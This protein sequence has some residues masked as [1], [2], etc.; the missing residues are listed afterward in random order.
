MKSRKTIRPAN[1]KKKKSKGQSCRDLLKNMAAQLSNSTMSLKSKKRRRGKSRVTARSLYLKLI[2]R[3]C[4][5]SK[6]KYNKKLKYKRKNFRVKTK[7]SMKFTVLMP[8]IKNPRREMKECST[9]LNITCPWFVLSRM[10]T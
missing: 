2:M 4:L 10:K 7:E 5:L 1:A 8:K 6:D 3:N 9:A